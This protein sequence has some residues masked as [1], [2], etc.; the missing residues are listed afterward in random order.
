MITHSIPTKEEVSKMTTKEKLGHMTM[1]FMWYRGMIIQ[2][3][4]DLE[5]TLDMI[6]TA[7]FNPEMPNDFN[8]FLL[9][10]GFVDFGRKVNIL[11]YILDKNGYPDFLKENSKKELT[12]NSFINE[13]RE[14]NSK[15]ND[16][17]HCKLA[18]HDEVAREYD[19]D[20]ISFW[21]SKNGTTE[22]KAKKM[23]E[24]NLELKE[25]IDINNR[26]IIFLNTN[27]ST[28]KES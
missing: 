12:N 16:L 6:L 27:F 2:H 15:R 25:V 10:T 4:I 22:I 8:T 18:G 23:S 17:A 28:A 1:D 21:S 20:R 14:W 5:M 7:Y 26:L 24:F 9:N 13:L 11:S 3:L 19:G